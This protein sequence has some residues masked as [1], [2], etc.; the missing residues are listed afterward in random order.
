MRRIANRITTSSGDRKIP[1]VASKGEAAWV[2]EQGEIPESDDKFGQITI[3]AYK[4]A[5]MIRISIELLKDSAFDMA[6]YIAREFGRR[7]GSKEEE[8]FLIGDGVGKPLGLLAD[9]GGAEIGITTNS[10]TALHLDDV[11]DLYYSL[12]TPYRRTATFILHDTT[13]KALRKFKDSNGQYLW[14]PSI[15]EGTPDMILNRPML[16]SAY[17]PP[18]GAGAKAMLFGDMRYYWI[19]D[20]Q[21]RVFQRLNELYAKTGQ[22]GFLAYERVDGRLVLPE[23]VKALQMKGTTPEPAPEP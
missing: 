5:T 7:I 21:G 10:E 8:A 2:D 18:L 22:V 1:V 13:V 9:T 3:G 4:L 11:I 16:T 19:A 14:Q 23:G 20:R 17:M 12:K 15:K 6:S